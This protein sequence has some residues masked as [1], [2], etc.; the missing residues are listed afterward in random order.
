MTN[1]KKICFLHTVG[2]SLV[3]D[4]NKHYTEDRVYKKNL[5]CFARLTEL[6]YIISYRDK[7][8]IINLKEVNIII[9]N[10]ICDVL[11]SFKK[12]LEDVSIIVSHD[13]LYHLNT[14]L[15]IFIRY[16]ILF[17]FDK[18]IIIDNI[19]FYHNIKNPDIKL[20]YNKLLNKKKKVFELEMIKE[21][22]IFLYNNYELNIPISY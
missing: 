2:K 13:C 11:E 3:C 19:N 21:S 5:Y 14:L 12:D 9:K 10:N 15:A 6:N 18:F 22:F 17:S 1:N 7:N 16:N 4:K 20:L 8:K